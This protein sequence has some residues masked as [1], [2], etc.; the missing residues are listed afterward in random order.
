MD[1]NTK[2]KIEQFIAINE[3]VRNSRFSKETKNVGFQLNFEVGKPLEQKVT[4]FDEEDL[5]SMLLDLRKFTL[6]GDKDGVYIPNI[7]DLL[8]TNTSNQDTISSVQKCKDFYDKLMNEPAI[9][10]IIDSQTETGKD[11]LDKWLYGHYFH[12]EERRQDLKDLGVG[13]QIHK[14]NFVIAV[15]DLIRLSTVLTDYAKRVIAV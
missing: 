4:G 6:R 5:R 1:L 2:N 3:K 13:V 8:I 14:A 15:T 11:V 10:M 7:C 12:E 9:K